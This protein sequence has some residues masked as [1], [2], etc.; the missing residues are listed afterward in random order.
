MTKTF[1]WLCRWG[2]GNEAVV[3]A[4]DIEGARLEVRRLYGAQGPIYARLAT[5][6]EAAAA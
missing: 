6:A 2:V 5:R 3:Q 1:A 4:A